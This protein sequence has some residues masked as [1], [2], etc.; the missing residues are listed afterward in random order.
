[1][2]PVTNSNNKAGTSYNLRCTQTG[3]YMSDATPDFKVIAVTHRKPFAFVLPCEDAAEHA[4]KFMKSLYGSFDWTA[5]PV[6]G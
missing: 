2:S 4:R 3:L 5:V 1:M 6:E